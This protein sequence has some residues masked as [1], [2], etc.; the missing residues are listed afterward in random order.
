MLTD[1]D[2]GA[3]PNGTFVVVFC[4]VGLGVLLCFYNLLRL[5]Y[6][7]DWLHN[8]WTLVQNKHGFLAQNIKN[9]KVRAEH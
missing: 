6:K 4:L 2:A 9:F 5:N 7:Q 1:P 3:C 8:M